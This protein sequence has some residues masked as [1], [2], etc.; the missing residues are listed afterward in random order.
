M[1]MWSF[2]VLYVAY[3]CAQCHV[4]NACEYIQGSPYYSSEWAIV[5]G[6]DSYGAIII[7]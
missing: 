4:V 3:K 2:S 7:L 6:F 5:A 1:C